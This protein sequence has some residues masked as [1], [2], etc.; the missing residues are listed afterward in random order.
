M[1]EV[2]K[3]KKAYVIWQ[4]T[5]DKEEINEIS[6]KLY[7]N[8]DSFGYPEELEYTEVQK[9]KKIN[10]AKRMLRNN[11]RM[12]KI[13]ECTGLTKSEIIIIT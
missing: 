2:K 12:E 7:K 8:L 13:I 11:E 10:M 9:M 1:D 4:N 6:K 5:N 3:E